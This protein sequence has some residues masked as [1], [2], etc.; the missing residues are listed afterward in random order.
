MAVMSSLSMLHVICY[1]IIFVFVYTSSTVE[2][3]CLSKYERQSGGEK[4]KKR[5]PL[6]PSAIPRRVVKRMPFRVEKEGF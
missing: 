3:D 4:S 6:P 1:P 2:W 5:R